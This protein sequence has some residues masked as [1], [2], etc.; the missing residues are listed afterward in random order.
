MRAVDHSDALAAARQQSRRPHGERE[1][2]AAQPPDVRLDVHVLAVRRGRRVIGVGLGVALR[3]AR[4][5]CRDFLRRAARARCSQRVEARQERR[6]WTRQ[7]R[8]QGTRQGREGE[9]EGE[10]WSERVCD[11]PQQQQSGARAAHQLRRA[12]R[13]P[14]TLHDLDAGRD[15]N[16]TPTPTDTPLPLHTDAALRT[17]EPQRVARERQ[18]AHCTDHRVR[19]FFT[20]LTGQPTYCCSHEESALRPHPLQSSAF[21]HHLHTLAGAYSSRPQSKL[22]WTLSIYSLNYTYSM[23]CDSMREYLW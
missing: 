13:P 5:L 2:R 8:R 4:R 15:A 22:V 1:L 11:G 16:P 17:R 20:G 7:G 14:A 3:H 10:G 21:R 19:V 18:L 6:Q 23:N 9:G 12:E